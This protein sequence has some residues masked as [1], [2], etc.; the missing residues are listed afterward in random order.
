MLFSKED[1]QLI[2][3]SLFWSIPIATR[4]K[5]VTGFHKSGCLGNLQDLRRAL[6][7]RN[8]NQLPLT[9]ASNCLEGTGLWQGNHL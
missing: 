7:V 9:I 5:F 2:S 8:G 4:P 1:I 3:H 6:S